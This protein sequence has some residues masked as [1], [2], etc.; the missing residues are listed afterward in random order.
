MQA[1]LEDFKTGWYGLTLGLKSKEI[2]QLITTLQD[3]KKEKTHFHFRSEFEGAGGI[4]DI[5]FYFQT[6]SQP[7]NLEIESSC[8]ALEK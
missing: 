6:E 7:S 1:D 8:K 4:G 2:D 3:L 5:E